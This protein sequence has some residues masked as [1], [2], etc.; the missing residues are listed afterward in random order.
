MSDEAHFELN[1]TV[2]KQ[3]CKFWGIANPTQ[4][5]SRFLHPRKVTV[6]CGVTAQFI[7]KTEVTLLQSTAHATDK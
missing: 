5:Q 6:K 7:K 3:N 1:G 4:T 2:N